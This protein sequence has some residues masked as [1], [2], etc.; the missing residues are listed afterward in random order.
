MDG[1][2]EELDYNDGLDLGEIVDDLEEEEVAEEPAQRF[3]RQTD[4]DD[5][6]E[7]KA[8][9]VEKSHFDIKAQEP[10]KEIT[11]E[12]IQNVYDSLEVDLLDQSIRATALFVQT[13]NQLTVYELERIFAEF[14]PVRCALLSTDSGV[15]RFKDSF[16]AAEA[17]YHITKPV[18]RIRYSDTQEDGEL[19]DEDDEDAEGNILR[20]EEGDKVLIIKDPEHMPKTNSIELDLSQIKVPKGVWRLVTEH[21]PKD[22][23]VFVK[24]STGYQLRTSMLNPYNKEISEVDARSSQAEYDDRDEFKRKRVRPGLNVFDEKGK[25]LD[26]DYE[27]DTRFFEDYE[28]KAK[29][30]PIPTGPE[31]YN[32]EGSKIR[33]RGRGSKKFVEALLDDSD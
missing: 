10:R 6:D 5:D 1:E 24:L 16:N 17:L 33:S 27:H 20:K 31:E 30:S 23:Y 9:P 26:W 15:V 13:T 18:L 8:R 29:K 14:E 25:E 3:D 12:D 21:V 2:Q 19:E 11:E 22:R 32:I 4:E 7:P 28:P